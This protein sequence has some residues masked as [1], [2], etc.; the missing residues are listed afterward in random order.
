MTDQEKDVEKTN[1]G[2]RVEGDIEEI[3][4]FAREVEECL[5]DDVEDK[6]IDEF[7]EWRPR[8]EDG[9]KEI[10]EKTVKVASISEKKVERETKGFK[11]DLADAR[12][13]IFRALKKFFSE[14]S[15]P[16][17]EIKEA[18][19]D[20]AKPVLNSS[21]VATR[22]LEEAIYSNMTRFNPYFFDAKEFSADLRAQKDGKYKMD[23]NIPDRNRRTSLEQRFE[24]N[25]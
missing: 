16:E 10:E 20:A 22:K 13:N 21:V 7:H 25:N 14:K 23:V 12:R 18:S 8:E 9:E 5:E 11:G 4:G 3:A 15:S 24:G 1:S 17:K 2:V 6:S 19:K